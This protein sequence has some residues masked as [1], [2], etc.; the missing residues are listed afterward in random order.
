M[1]VSRKRICPECDSRKITKLR[2][3]LFLK[4]YYCRECS[5]E[6]SGFRLNLKFF[7]I[8]VAFD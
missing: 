5:N 3:G 8:R 1:K 6:F 7:R 2:G 4:S